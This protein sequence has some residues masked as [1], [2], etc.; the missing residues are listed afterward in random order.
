MGTVEVSKTLAFSPS[1][2]PI[3]A[4]FKNRKDGTLAE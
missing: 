2:D 3:G 4:T 1:Y